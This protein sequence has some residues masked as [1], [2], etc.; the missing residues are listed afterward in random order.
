[1]GL[2]TEGIGAYIHLNPRSW[3]PIRLP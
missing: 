1:M 2:E 3:V